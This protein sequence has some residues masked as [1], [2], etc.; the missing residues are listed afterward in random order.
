MKVELG[1][2]GRDPRQHNQLNLDGCIYCLSEIIL[3]V[4]KGS[5]MRTAG[6]L[7]LS[8]LLLHLT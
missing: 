5:I 7:T 8:F 1:R 4:K 6:S 2:I 3:I